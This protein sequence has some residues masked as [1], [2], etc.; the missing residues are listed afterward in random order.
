MQQRIHEM[1]D[2][3]SKLK[4]A[5]NDTSVSFDGDSPAT[6]QLGTKRKLNPLLSIM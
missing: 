5:P 4:L 2:E 3:M 6:S 1:E